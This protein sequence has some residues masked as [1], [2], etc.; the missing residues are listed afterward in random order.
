MHISVYV[1]YVHYLFH[2]FLQCECTSGIS[3]PEI[4]VWS[5]LSKDSN[6]QFDIGKFFK[7]FVDFSDQYLYLALL[8]FFSNL[9]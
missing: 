2:I 9:N 3:T 5:A 8:R 1:Q 4:P 6:Q 7:E